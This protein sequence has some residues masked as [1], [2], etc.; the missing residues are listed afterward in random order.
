MYKIKEAFAVYTGGN[1]WLFYGSLEDGNYFMVD[2]NGWT[3]ILN[4]DPSNLDESTYSEWQDAHLVDELEH[5]ERVAFCDSLMDYLDINADHRGGMFESE[6]E[7]YREWF[8]SDN[9]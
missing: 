1:I 2:D 5:E 4:A 6:I 7:S 8:K 3:Q 9:F